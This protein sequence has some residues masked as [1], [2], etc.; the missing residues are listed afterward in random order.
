ML[1]DYQQSRRAYYQFVDRVSQGL[2]NT[3]RS[4]ELNELNFETR[5]LAVLS[6]IEQIVLNDEIRTLNEERGR[7]RGHGRAEILCRL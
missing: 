1:I 3:I 5:R 7:H 2:R 4:L 6:A